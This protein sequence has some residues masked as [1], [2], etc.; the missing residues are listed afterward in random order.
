MRARA[1]LELA[2]TVSAAGAVGALVAGGVDALGAPDATVALTE[3]G[4]VA[5]VTWPVAIAVT[6]VARVGWWVW[7]PRDLS[8]ALTEPGG[9]APRL[10]AWLIYLATSAIALGLAIGGA[11]AWQAQHTAFLPDVVMLA[12]PIVG[13]AA[14]GALVLASRPILDVLTR[15]LR[16]LDGAYARRRGRPLLTPRR[17]LGSSALLATIGLAA[18]WRLWLA[19]SLAIHDLARPR[20]F[21]LAVLGALAVP[22][23]LGRLP[24]WGRTGLG[25]TAVA[26]ALTLGGLALWRVEDSPAVTLEV[27]GRDQLASDA[28]EHL[29]ELEDLRAHVRMPGAEPTP[30]DGVATHPP[31][32]LVTIDTVRADRTPLTGGPARMPTLARL[33]T[34]GAN[35]TRAYA[36]GNVTRRSIPTMITGL[37]PPRVHGKVAGWALRLDPRHITLAERFRAAGYATAGFFCCES[38]WGARHRLGLGRGID[39]L[40]IQRDGAALVDQAAA[41]LTARRQRPGEPYFLWLHFIEPH[42]WPKADVIEADT[43]R[44]GSRYARYDATLAEVDEFLTT[45]A[46]AVPPEP[47]IWVVTS[48]HGEGL[49]DHG[50]RFHSTNL[51]ESQVHV[52]LVITGPGIAARKIDEPVGLVG[53]VPTL[54]ELAGFAPPPDLDGGAFADLA[55]GA[56]PAASDAGQAFSYMIADRS[57]PDSVRAVVRG[58]WKLIATG[59]RR[60]LYD[61]IADPREQRDRKADRPEVLAELEALLVER[62]ALD[63]ASPFAP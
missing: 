17:L 63:R 59:G 36:P 33:G 51:Y 11:V 5:A 52:P 34:T 12:T 57:V 21:G 53:L 9:A 15:I 55:T 41:W 43:P 30:R 47:P 4:L 54:L 6:L 25:A 14:A 58:R 32:I 23:L 2:G 35:F 24:R 22:L 37:H 1:V 60:E 44:T 46:E 50:A 31:V 62:A 18:A 40:T 26:S 39:E 19:P 56:R 49:G 61:V 29:V 13:V 42:G 28:I 7:R 45:L 3:A 48:D 16:R 10:G 27:W 38:F 8:G 20:A